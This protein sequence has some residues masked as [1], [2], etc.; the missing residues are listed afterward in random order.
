MLVVLFLANKASSDCRL[1]DMSSIIGGSDYTVKDVRATAIVAG[2]VNILF[3]TSS[4]RKHTDAMD[5][6]LMF[7]FDYSLCQALF[8][9]EVLNING[10]VLDHQVKDTKI[11]LLAYNTDGATK[12][13]FV[14]VTD[15]RPDANNNLFIEVIDSFVSVPSSV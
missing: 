8:L 3:V 1:Q 4:F 9:T 2:G 14:I 13:E 15:V 6:V 7:L 11:T 12:S 10:G 5:K